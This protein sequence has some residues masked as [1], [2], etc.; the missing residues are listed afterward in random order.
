MEQRGVVVA[1]A[2]GTSALAGCISIGGS[3]SVHAALT[4]ATVRH[5]GGA[6]HVGSFTEV[7]ED[8][9]V[10]QLLY[11]R[12]L[13]PLGG[14]AEAI[15]AFGLRVSSIGA[16]GGPGVYA[17]TSY[18]KR[19]AADGPLAS[20]VIAGAGISYSAMHP[21]EHGRMW[22]G[23]ALGV[24]YHRERQVNVD[25]GRPGQFVGLELTAIGGFDSL[26]PMYPRRPRRALADP[27]R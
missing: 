18:G 4:D 16:D 1:I 9:L 13:G 23:L 20:T 14:Q 10:L 7:V 5:G 3:G 25:G 27:L 24:V 8:R 6:L 11:S 19:A 21:G 26:G 2:L 22:A 17:M 12:D 15:G